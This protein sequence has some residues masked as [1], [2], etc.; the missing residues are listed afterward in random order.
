MHDTFVHFC[1]R[2]LERNVAVGRYVIMPDH[3]HLFL[4]LP[5]EGQTLGPWIKALKCVL[6]RELEHAGYAAPHWQEGFFDHL[7]RSA[8]SYAGKWKYVEQ[9]PLRAQLCGRSEDWPFQGEIVP[10]PF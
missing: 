6:G 3:V 8:E 10:I 1:R 2:A 4:R 5:P 9:N 7:M